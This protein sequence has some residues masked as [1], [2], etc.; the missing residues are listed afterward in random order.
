MTETERTLA[1][2]LAADQKSSAKG[3]LTCAWLA[4]VPAALADQFDDAFAAKWSLKSI[5]RAMLA[6]GARMSYASL[7]LHRKRGHD[8][9]DR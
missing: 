7:D 2:E 1:E 3:C 5:H 6:R 9:D 4:S 8:D